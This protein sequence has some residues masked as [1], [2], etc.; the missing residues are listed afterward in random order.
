MKCTKLLTIATLAVATTLSFNAQAADNTYQAKAQS[1]QKSNDPNKLI[2]ETLFSNASPQEKARIQEQIKKYSQLQYGLGTPA[3]NP[4]PK[5]DADVINN[6]KA[7]DPATVKAQM[8][9][10]REAA[11]ELPHLQQIQKSKVTP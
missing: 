10:M 6:I 4:S 9:K 5:K 1:L 8:E 3:A 2:T 7:H 11:K